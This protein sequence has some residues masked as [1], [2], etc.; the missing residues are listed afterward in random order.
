MKPN[1]WKDIDPYLDLEDVGNTSNEITSE[2][3]DVQHDQEA[4]KK[5]D[6]RIRTVKLRIPSRPRRR[7]SASARYTQ[8]DSDS[9]IA[10]VP[11]KKPCKPRVDPS[12]APSHLRCSHSHTHL[13]HLG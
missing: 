9:D 7:A 6:L 12:G 11:R 8:S 13:A 10:V 5:Y 1:A 3:K 4:I 2:S